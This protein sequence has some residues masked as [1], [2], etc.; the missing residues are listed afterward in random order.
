MSIVLVELSIYPTQTCNTFMEGK[1]LDEIIFYYVNG[2]YSDTDDVL[3]KNLYTV[4]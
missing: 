1:F 3:I 4:C 2:V